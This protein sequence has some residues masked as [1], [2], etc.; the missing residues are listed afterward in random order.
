VTVYDYGR[1]H[2]AATMSR[3]DFESIDRTFRPSTAEAL[4]RR[5]LIRFSKEGQPTGQSLLK[6]TR[7][8]LDQYIASRETNGGA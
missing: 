7:A 5:S 6:P 8:G 4:H 2:D 3:E 1:G